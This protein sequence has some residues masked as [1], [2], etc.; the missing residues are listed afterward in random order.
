MHAIL[1]AKR[2]KF[3]PYERLQTEDAKTELE[4]G[5]HVEGK[6]GAKRKAL[7]ALV[8]QGRVTR[9]GIGRKGDPFTYK[10]SFPRSPHIAG[11]REQESEKRPPAA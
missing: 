6:T 7:R 5:E 11:T 10:C 1:R 9:E 8:E 3:Y 2:R 4:I